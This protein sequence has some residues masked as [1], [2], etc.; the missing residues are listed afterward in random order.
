MDDHF[1]KQIYRQPDDGTGNP[2]Y[3]Y[4]ADMVEFAEQYL[5]L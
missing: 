2:R 4:V 1:S 5:P 3:F